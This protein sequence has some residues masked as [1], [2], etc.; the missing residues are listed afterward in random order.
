MKGQ[1]SFFLPQTHSSKVHF[2]E[3]YYV[4][5]EKRLSHFIWNKTGQVIG[6][7]HTASLV[8]PELVKQKQQ[9]V[10]Y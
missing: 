8:L 5:K 7:L 10:C 6:Q 1:F 2:Q 4:N 3:P 9:Q